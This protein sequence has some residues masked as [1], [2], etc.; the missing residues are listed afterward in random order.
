MARI[1]AART[2]KCVIVRFALI[3]SEMH[4][5]LRAR[6]GRLGYD[7]RLETVLAKFVIEAF[8]DTSGCAGDEYNL[9]HVVLLMKPDVGCWL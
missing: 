7:W 2:R 4:W 1:N 9:V 6:I 3:P 8:A 5:C